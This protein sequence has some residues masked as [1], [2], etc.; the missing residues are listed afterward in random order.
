MKQIID[1][2]TLISLGIQAI[3]GL[4]GSVGLVVPLAPKHNILREVLTLELVVQTIEFIYYISFLFVLNLNCLTQKRYYDWF[5]TTPIML[6]TISLYFFYVNF[7]EPDEYNKDINTLF[8]F[9]KR[10][11]KVIIA[12]VVLNFIMLMFGFLTELGILDRSMSF[13][14]GTLAMCGSFGIIY[15]NYAKQSKNTR[16]MFWIM[17]IIWSMYGV[18]FLFP[19][20]LKNIG[21]TILDIFSKN[22]FGLFLT[23]IIYTK[24]SK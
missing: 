13:I 18:A 4:L 3:T 19:P 12:Y 6:F 7:I 15:N 20:I 17:F 22:F 14:L 21:Y 10:D 24:R 1:N 16:I 23:Y 11:Y 8:D 2:A 5:I 9:I